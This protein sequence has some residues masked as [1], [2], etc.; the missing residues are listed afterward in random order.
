MDDNIL[1]KL[2]N[3]FDYM[4]TKIYGFHMMNDIVVTASQLDDE[5]TFP[6]DY[7]KRYVFYYKNMHNS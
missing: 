7:Y 5:F 6:M 4:Q 3:L 2:D 1:R